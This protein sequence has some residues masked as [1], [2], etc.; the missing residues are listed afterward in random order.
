VAVTG[1]D[2]FSLLTGN[3][4]ATETGRPLKDAGTLLSANAYLGVDG[5]L[6]ALR[7]SPNIIITGRVADPSLFL[8]PMIHA[9]NWSRDDF[10]LLG[11]GTVVGH[12]LECAGQITGGYYADP[13]LKAVPDMEHLGHPFADVSDDGTA[14]I[15]K[16]AGTGGVVNLHTAKEQL[17]Y[18]VV[19]PHAYFT[20]DVVANFTTV[21][22]EQVGPDVV[23]VSGGSGTARPATFKTSVGY[24]AL[25][26]GE[27][28]ITYAGPNAVARARHAADIVQK[29]LTPFFPDLRVDLIGHN[30]VH[31]ESF[32][33]RQ[34]PYEVRLRI[35]GKALTS[36]QAA[37]VGEEV[38]ALYTNGPAG[39]GGVRRYVNEVVGI[40]SVLLDRSKVIHQTTRYRH[41]TL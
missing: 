36:E 18:E 7:Q 19:N 39:G 38:E 24:Q 21:R 30:S 22:L 1:D 8:G 20:P 9:F 5:I 31:G 16:V 6:E 25:F 37:L 14:L 40:I 23:K 3:E 11:Q 10:N 2:V 32:I 41:E 13:P 29:R 26:L 28:E 15:S 34:Q 17:L 35:A 4:I 33:D 12:L 27:G